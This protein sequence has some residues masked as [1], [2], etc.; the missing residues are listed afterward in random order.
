LCAG[1]GSFL[2]LKVIRS[3]P[4]VMIV[5]LNVKVF[6]KKNK[7]LNVILTFEFGMRKEKLAGWR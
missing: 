1:C 4:I 7:V 6:I 5:V 2:I 3:Y